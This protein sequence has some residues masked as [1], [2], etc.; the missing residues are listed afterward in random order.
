MDLREL[1]AEARQ[2]VARQVNSTLVLLYW[3]I[4]QHIR[5]D[6]LK[7]KRADYGEQIVAT[8]SRRLGWSHF[9]EIIPLDDDPLKRD[10]YAEICCI[11]QWGAN[12]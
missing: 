10:F 9:K 6:I 12:W 1:I 2:Y 3:R 5:S 7:E 8:L 11:E 4:G